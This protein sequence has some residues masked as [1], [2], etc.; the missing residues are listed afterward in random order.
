MGRNDATLDAD[1]FVNPAFSL[2]ALNY[3]YAARL[4]NVFRQHVHNKSHH[5]KMLPHLIILY[6]LFSNNDSLDSLD[7]EKINMIMHRIEA[8]ANAADQ[9]GKFGD[10]YIDSRFAGL[11]L[12]VS[13]SIVNSIIGSYNI[14]S[15][16]FKINY[17]E[18][19]KM[20]LM[21]INELTKEQLKR[22]ILFLF[23]VIQNIRFIA[24]QLL[25]AL[26]KKF[27]D[28]NTTVMMELTGMSNESAGHIES[29]A[30]TSALISASGVGFDKSII[31]YGKNKSTIGYSF[32][33]RLEFDS[34]IADLLKV[35]MY[36][37]LKATTTTLPF[38]VAPT[39]ATTSEY[40]PIYYY[41]V[42]SEYTSIYLLWGVASTITFNE[43]V[44]LVG[45]WMIGGGAGGGGAYKSTDASIGAGG[46][47]GSAGGICVMNAGTSSPVSIAANTTYN[48]TI[49]FGGAAG[50]GGGEIGGG[51]VYIS[52]AGGYGGVTT[53][54]YFDD[55]ANPIFYI[56]C[57][58]G[59]GGYQGTI[60]TVG[61]GGAA[62]SADIASG[63]GITY[64]IT[65]VTYNSGGGGGCVASS[66]DGTGE[67][68]IVSYVTSPYSLIPTTYYYME[69][70][71]YSPPTL[72]NLGGGG[73]G[74]SGNKNNAGI[75]S[76]NAGC[77]GNG[78]GGPSSCDDGA[79]GNG[80]TYGAGGG[81]GAFNVNNYLGSDGG[82]G[83]NGVIIITIVTN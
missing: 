24:A 9:G 6:K 28:P 52:G 64:P 13:E 44:D 8:A 32:L 15:I 35:K 65:P 20:R 67:E 14:D 42:G 17:L 73:G 5:V 79:G 11:P 76:A 71:S 22:V 69:D 7:M 33:M 72:V 21:K 74:A 49:G 55:N 40:E 4:Y 81:G 34:I 51:G 38:T 41:N 63:T 53:L 23:N 19:L 62:V 77:G 39:S 80:L 48:F 56:S 75:G 70:L 43:D 18:E 60:S 27:L 66:S 61:Q 26:I 47:G 82:S 25:Q 30:G 29:A 54:G 58:G 57:E 37:N 45:I 46:G 36:K 12:T 1:G 3:P 31:K 50:A 2:A 16:V 78:E 83:S 10:K 59:N 68:T